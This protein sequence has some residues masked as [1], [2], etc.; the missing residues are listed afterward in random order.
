MRIHVERD[1]EVVIGE[2]GGALSAAELRSSPLLRDLRALE[3]P[4]ELAVEPAAFASWRAIVA[5]EA[6]ADALSPAAL[7]AAHEV[8][9]AVACV[10]VSVIEGCRRL[11]H[12]L[13]SGGSRWSRTTQRRGRLQ[14]CRPHAHAGRR[15]AR[16]SA[17]LLSRARRSASLR[18]ARGPGLESADAVHASTQLPCALWLQLRTAHTAAA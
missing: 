2:G 18:R 8:R 15:S 17:S 16:G 7:A 13:R 10:C 6:T 14:R 1:G 3:G 4:A 12:I 11:E 9:G 5:D